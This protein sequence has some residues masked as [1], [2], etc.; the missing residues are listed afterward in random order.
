LPKSG[1]LACRDNSDEGEAADLVTVAIG[2][3]RCSTAGKEQQ[4]RKNK[5]NEKGSSRCHIC[6]A[7]A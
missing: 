6:H 3:T 7:L 4:I 2:H 1:T 5:Q